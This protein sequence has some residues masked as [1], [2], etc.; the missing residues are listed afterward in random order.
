[1][2]KFLLTSGFK[3]IDP[4]EFD[5]N[6]FISNSRKGCALEFDLEFPKELRKLHNVY[7]LA[8]DRI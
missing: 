7:S 5:L 8:L 1:M 6:K 3:W 2:S 4:R